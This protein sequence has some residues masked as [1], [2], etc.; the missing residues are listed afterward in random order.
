MANRKSEIGNSRFRLLAY[1]KRWVEDNARLKIVV[2]A[3]QI[4]YSFAATLRVVLKCLEGKTTWILLSKGERQ[5]RLLME[6]VQAH[7]QACG[8][9][10]RAKESVFFEGTSV[11]QLEARFA[12]GSVIYALAANPETARGYSG[13][14]TLDEFAFHAEAAKIYAALFPSIT[15]GYSMEVIST[16]NGTQG[17]FYELAKMAGLTEED[18]E[19]RSQGKSG[20][21]ETLAPRRSPVETAVWSGHRCDVYEAARQG[22]RLNLPMLRSGCDD[23]TTWQQE[24]CCGFVSLA[25]NFF[26]PELLAA[27]LSAEATTDWLGAAREGSAGESEFF[28]GI[29]VGRRQDRTVFWVDEALGSGD[30]GEGSEAA[31]EARQRETDGRLSVARM[32]RVM[33]RAPFAEQLETARELLS[34]RRPDGRWA[35]RRAAI[36][37]TGIGAMLAETLEEEFA[38]RVEAVNFTSA[39]KED[40]AF[41]T[42]RRMEAGAT[43]LPE[44]RAIRRA[45]SAV[46]KLATA[47][48]H[49]RFDAAR[50]EAGHADEFWAKALA[51]LA[52]DERPTSRLREGFL[53]AAR[54]MV[55]ARRFMETAAGWAA[56]M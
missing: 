46:K 35:I 44:T 2:K 39:V 8:A 27:C 23:G 3:R 6:K 43:R 15:R 11:R 36:D 17:K 54:P 56:V 41:R 45:F 38:P 42:R 1:Q 55:D 32:V 33:E 5:S 26:S 9:V 31:P 53:A 12:N 49:L 4:G 34:A 52:A 14:V 10:A 51:D 16:P 22:L 29:D 24:Y 37:A 47:S 28:L 7:V 48:G 50:T 21:G 20:Q 18:W 19:A 30:R 40:L 13:N 25:E